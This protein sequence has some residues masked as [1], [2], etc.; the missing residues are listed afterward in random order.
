MTGLTWDGDICHQQAVGGNAQETPI[1]A[2]QGDFPTIPV[3][4]EEGVR[5]H[6][7]PVSYDCPVPPL[8]RMWG[9]GNQE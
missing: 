7:V 3:H 9:P 1:G 5:L 4:S 2:L 6:G 8:V